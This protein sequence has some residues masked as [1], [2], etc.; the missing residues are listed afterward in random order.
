MTS[1]NSRFADCSSSMT[2]TWLTTLKNA[3]TVWTAQKGQWDLQ[4]LELA[5]RARQNRL[6]QPRQLL[7]ARRQNH[8]AK[9]TKLTRKRNPLTQN[10]IKCIW[11]S[12]PTFRVPVPLFVVHLLFLYWLQV[13]TDVSIPERILAWR[14]ARGQVRHTHETTPNWRKNGPTQVHGKLGGGVHKR[15]VEKCTQPVTFLMSQCKT[16]PPPPDFREWLAN[17]N[18]NTFGWGTLVYLPTT[19]GG[20]CGK[21]GLHS[22]NWTGTR[23]CEIQIVKKKNQLWAIW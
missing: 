9:G 13:N 18:K 4:R 20:V 16:P 14:A 19:R 12:K 6:R 7:F 3:S 21:N 10:P 2:K 23:T 22:K 11:I 1:P 8:H 15:H 5:N 17:Y